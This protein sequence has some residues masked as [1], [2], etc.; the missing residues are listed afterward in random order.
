MLAGK[1]LPIHSARRSREIIQILWPA[2]QTLVARASCEK[3]RADIDAGGLA[4]ANRRLDFTPKPALSLRVRLRSNRDSTIGLV[5]EGLPRLLARRGETIGQTTV[6]VAIVQVF[7]S[8]VS[9]GA[10]VASLALELLS[11]RGRHQPEIVFG[12]LEIVLRGDRVAGCVSVARQLKVSFRHM[13][14]RASNSA[15]G[16]A[17]VI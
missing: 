2:E 1:P 12:V 4:T 15:V 17:R 14:R 6:I 3:D 16:S 13:R 8:G 10:N 9:C 11:L 5:A 7:R